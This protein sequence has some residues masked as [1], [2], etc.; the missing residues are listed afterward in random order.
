MATCR[1]LSPKVMK[2]KLK[3]KDF[4]FVLITSGLVLLKALLYLWKGFHEGFTVWAWILIGMCIIYIPYAFIFKRKGFA[5]YYL[6]YCCI[7]I[8]VL[9]FTKTY[10]YNN[11]TALFI[12]YII[13]LI[14]P[15]LKHVISIG[16]IILVSI[17]FAL[18]EESIYHYLLHMTNGVWFYYISVFVIEQRFNRKHLI[19]FDDE[20]KILTQ[21]CNNHLQKSIEFEGYSESTIYR[22]LK[23]AMARNHMTKKELIEEFR[24]EYKDELKI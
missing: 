16:Y 3:E 1:E 7:L 20:V 24:K 13:F 11:Y 9:A 21:L 22:R 18:N 17:A 10:L 2:E 12:A 4:S 8:F 23:A 15:N 6:F 14:K 19:L 5:Y